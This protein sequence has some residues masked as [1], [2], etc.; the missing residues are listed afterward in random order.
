MAEATEETPE[1]NT[2]K[3]ATIRVIAERVRQLEKG[4]PPMATAKGTSLMDI[5]MA[6]IEAGKIEITI[7]ES[8]LR[9]SAKERAEES[10]KES[11]KESVAEDVA[12]KAEA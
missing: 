2:N 7:D 4:A 10:A 3:F 9:S 1:K 11:A 12:E 5:A 8:G 6:E